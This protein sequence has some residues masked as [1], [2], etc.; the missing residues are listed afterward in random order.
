MKA[1]N[2]QKGFTL[3]EILL[4]IAIIGIILSVS[5][6][7]SFSMYSGYKS[8]LK[9]QEVMIFISKLKRESFLYS[10]LRT[11]SSKNNVITIDGE[12]KVFDDSLINIDSP[13]IFYRNGTTSGGLVKVD[14]GGS[15][16]QLAVRAPLGDLTMTRTGAE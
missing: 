8:A 15:V 16:Y 7:I 13:I 10:E 11:L 1:F 2:K 14:T 9:A 5:L 4:V 3:I 12:E 6:P